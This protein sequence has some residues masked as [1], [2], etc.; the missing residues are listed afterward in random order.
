[1]KCWNRHG[2]EERRCQLF[3]PQFLAASTITSPRAYSVGTAIP[4]LPTWSASTPIVYNCANGTKCVSA[5]GRQSRGNF[6]NAQILNIL[7]PPT[8]KLRFQPV[9]AK[10]V[11]PDLSPVRFPA[12]T[13]A[14]A[15]CG[16]LFATSACPST[17][18]VAP[19]WTRL[20]VSQVGRIPSLART[21]I[22]SVQA[23]PARRQISGSR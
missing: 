12:T 21:P 9:H 11:T 6:L 13:R 2:N 5:L 22:T 7:P 17:T 8:R 20:T 3:P 10:P 18:R 1:V 16:V 19:S 15:T 4:H 14:P 23:G